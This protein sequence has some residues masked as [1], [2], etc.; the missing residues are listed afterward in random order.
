MWIHMIVGMRDALVPD[1]KSNKMARI[2]L[3]SARVLLQYNVAKRTYSVRYYDVH[4]NTHDLGPYA[5]ST[6]ELYPFPNA[7][8]NQHHFRVIMNSAFLP[9]RQRLYDA[10]F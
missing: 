8:T 3:E 7:T 2:T 5:K 10:L 1:Y 4:Y 9:P 6:D